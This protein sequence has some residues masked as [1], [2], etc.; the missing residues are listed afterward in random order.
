MAVYPNFHFASSNRKNLVPLIYSLGSP[1]AVCVIFLLHD[2]VTFIESC[3][4][5]QLFVISYVP[6]EMNM[7]PEAIHFVVLISQPRQVGIQK[8]VLKLRVQRFSCC[9]LKGR[10]QFFTCISSE[11][12]CSLATRIENRLL[13]IQVY[14]RMNIIPA[15]TSHF[16]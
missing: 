2:V 7:Y 16:C 3:L 14:F 11:L 1:V 5:S 6:N 12:T 10:N 13:L 4:N 9:L 8:S 15:I